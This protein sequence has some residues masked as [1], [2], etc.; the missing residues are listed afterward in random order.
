VISISAGSVMEE[1]GP[2][3]CNAAYVAAS[4]AAGRVWPCAR[5]AASGRPTVTGR[6]TSTPDRLRIPVPVSGWTCKDEDHL[7]VLERQYIL[8]TLPDDDEETYE[9]MK[10]RRRQFMFRRTTAEVVTEYKQ[11]AV[12]KLL[13]EALLEYV[14]FSESEN[15][16]GQPA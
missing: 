10:E 3:T 14:R 13:S 15:Q 5:S 7:Q 8:G 4:E 1:V 16:T 6:A 11:R 2:A 9:K 12:L